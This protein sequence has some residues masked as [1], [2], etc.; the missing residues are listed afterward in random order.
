MSQVS[1][2]ELFPGVWLRA[3]HTNKFKSSYLS[4]TLMTPLDRE[5]AGVNALI[6]SVLR[7]GTAVHPDM[8]TLSAALDELYGGAI[9]PVVRKKGETQ[10][11]GFAASFLDDAYALRGE[12]LLEPAAGLL[13]EL[14]LKPYTQDG[15]FCP[16]Y[17][18]GEKANLIDR[19]R[20]QINDKRTYAVQR[21]TQEMCRYEAFGV[22]KL[23]SEES[24]AAVTPESL[25]ER[26]QA[27]LHTAQ[28]EVY[29]CGS[30]DPDRVAGAL[31]SALD[32]LPVNENR[33]D[34]DCEVRVTAGPEPIVV[35]EAMD[36]SQG[37][38][39]L[40]FRTGGQTCWEENFPALYLAAAVYGG[41]TLSKLFMNVREKLSLCYYASAT[42]ER[43]KGL[44]LV[45]SGIEF[46]KYQTAKDEILAQ[47]EAVKR[48]EIEDWEL[49]GSRRTLIGACMSTLDDQGRQEDYW[50]GQAAAG[51]EYGPE[52]LAARLE[53]VTREQVAEAARRLELDTIYFLKGKEG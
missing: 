45:S 41:T 32:R 9:E 53:G 20:A 21:L 30:A 12:R 3:V 7:R 29:Y 10:C 27:L 49:E 35:E 11:L 17:T 52:E 5:Q 23:G 28:V 13:G 34:P 19:I 44:V 36:V 31:R 25:W 39:A 16:D 40:G 22:D 6:P 8:E 26:Y 4:L 15:R 51:L 24:V 43:M 48:G 46:D 1:R 37:K 33:I 2:R 42:L 47:L 14:L 38:L 50:L 18:A